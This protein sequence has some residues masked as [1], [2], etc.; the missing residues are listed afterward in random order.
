M[1]QRLDDDLLDNGLE[2]ILQVTGSISLEVA[3][4]VKHLGDGTQLADFFDIVICV[5]IIPSGVAAD[6]NGAVLVGG[7]S[8][9]G[10]P[11]AADGAA[12]GGIKFKLTH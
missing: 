7:G 11:P 1:L 2:G 12:G 9:I 8:N 3:V 6:G 5:I 10:V 4:G